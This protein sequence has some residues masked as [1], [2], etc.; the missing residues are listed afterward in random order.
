MPLDIVIFGLS[1]SSSWGNGHATT[2]RSIL[3]ALDKRGHRILFAERDVPW[4]RD[5]RD[6]PD[7][8]FCELY[9]YSH[10]AEVPTGLLPRVRAA[11]LVILGSYV[12]DGI[13]LADW[14]TTQ[15]GGTTAFYD[16]DTPVTLAML[17][18]NE[19][20]YMTGELV[21][22][23]DLYLSFAGG[24]VL[25]IL[26]QEYG[27]P[28]ARAL[29]CS[30]DLD[31]HRPATAAPPA[32]D[33]GYLGTYSADRQPVLT[34]LLIKPAEALPD[35]RFVVAGPQYP[36]DVTFPGNVA[37]IDHVAPADHAAFFSRQRFTLNVTR[38]EMALLGYAPSVR[39]LEAAACASTIVSDTWPGLDTIFAPGREILLA[40]RAEDVI[41]LL[42]RLRDDE[43]VAIGAAARVRVEAD[44]T[45][46]RR[47][48]QLEHLIAEARDKRHVEHVNNVEVSS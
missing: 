7:P 19:A 11:D 16:I 38:R 10:L 1:I 4:Y 45:G 48:E 23:F 24:P 42:T 9:L 39:L 33:L 34:E 2:Y 46:D 5:N 32:W 37:R 20:T 47:A 29:Y 25:D 26:E 43:R 6:L 41:D 27:S 14:I 44:H 28:C 13:A 3:K 36:A 8:D 30:A 31:T 22:R 35:R 15:A 17:A 21:P 40:T 12:P 18:R